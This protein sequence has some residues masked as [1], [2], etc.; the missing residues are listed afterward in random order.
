MMVLFYKNGSEKSSGCTCVIYHIAV[1]CNCSEPKCRC[2]EIGVWIIIA[3]LKTQ[4]GLIMLNRMVR[5][6]TE[7]EK[8]VT[9]NISTSDMRKVR[10]KK[11]YPA[12]LYILF[13]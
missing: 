5:G 8:K 3:K 4:I 10:T 6:Y 13:G 9:Y 2:C 7:D 12:S 11:Y 1:K